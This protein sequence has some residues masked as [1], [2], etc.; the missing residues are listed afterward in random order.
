MAH[1][2]RRIR[3]VFVALMAALSA[4]F[5]GAGAVGAVGEAELVSVDIAGGP[6]DSASFG[7]SISADSRYVAFLSLASDL[8]AGDSN[9]DYDAFVYDRVTGSTELASIG[10]DETPAGMVR[11][12]DIQISGNG[13][14]VVFCSL[15][16]NLAP[17]D[18]NGIADIFLYDR[19][20][21]TTERINISSAGDEANH[22]P[23]EDTENRCA[24][25]HSFDISHDGRF[26]VFES[27]A[28][29]HVPNDNNNDVDVFLRDRLLATTELLSIA[30]DGTQG[31]NG[32]IRPTV[33][34]D[35]RFVAFIVAAANTTVIPG[36]NNGAHDL[37]LRDRQ[38]GV[39]RLVSRAYDGTQADNTSHQPRI[40]GNGE[41]IVF[42]S[43]ATNLVAAGSDGRENIYVY[44][45]ASDSVSLLVENPTASFEP[46]VD[47]AARYVVFTSSG[48]AFGPGNPD[49]WQIY[50]VDLATGDLVKVSLA[51]DGSEGGLFDPTCDPTIDFCRAAISRGASVATTGAVAYQSDATNLVTGDTNNTSDIFVSDPP[52]GTFDDDAPVVTSVSASP[53][54]A[55]IGTLV[56]ISAVIDDVSTG[57]SDVVS[58]RYTVDGQS[59]TAMDAVDGAFDNATESVTATMS[60]AESGVHEICVSG[61][62]SPG[63]QSAPEC[64]LLAVYD[65]DGGFVTGGGWIDSPQGAYILDP[66]LTGRANFGFVSKYKNG[67]DTPTGETEFQFQV[68]DMNFH[69]DN[70]EWLVVAG[71]NAKY[72]GTGTINGSGTY[73]FMLTACDVAVSGG[74][75][76]EDADTFRIKIWDEDADDTVVYDNKEGAQHDS[77]A[78]TVL[79]GGNVKV[80]KG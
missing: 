73:G 8:V 6:A 39:T 19:E 77:H 43:T 64:V 23:G 50:R 66:S 69:S 46:D 18:T 75:Q 35:G 45:F 74:C 5:I 3:I 21:G 63:N 12:D 65:P 49:S 54:P 25:A 22:A 62:D 57:G 51:P 27:W 13:R 55:S 44:D 33:S 26:V 15:S 71:Q 52:D 4:L 38:L 60:F 2:R 28:S 9:T 56:V 34:D 30:T 10:L 16:S 1:L 32:S 67:A 7:P 68:A 17:S 80:H 42:Q 58:A 41:V 37:V 24:P 78:G 72:K 29:N 61:E 31:N 48:D 40:S 79:G 70:Y 59:P 76:G 11:G 36:D 53:N 14:L 20:N 47:E